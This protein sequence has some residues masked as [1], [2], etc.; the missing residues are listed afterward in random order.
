MF[1]LII[2]LKLKSKIEVKS[3]CTLYSLFSS[4]C[5]YSVQFL[6]I[7]SAL[8]MKLIC[9]SLSWQLGCIIYD[10]IIY[11]NI[12]NNNNDNKYNDDNNNI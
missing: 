9:N 4:S 6:L 2:T 8:D 12:N 1:G 3:V 11:N 7:I 5:F 10:L